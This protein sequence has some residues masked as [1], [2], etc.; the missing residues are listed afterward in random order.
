MESKKN[1]RGF[2]Q[3]TASLKLAFCY[4]LSNL[5]YSYSVAYQNYEMNW[6]G[7]HCIVEGAEWTYFCCCYDSDFL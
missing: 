4:L 6:E 5:D 1:D 2:I 3:E 7:E